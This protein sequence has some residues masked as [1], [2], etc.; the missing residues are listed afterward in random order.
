MKRRDFVAAMRAI[1]R[2][3][4]ATHRV[5]DDTSLAYSLLVMAIEALTRTVEAPLASWLEYDQAKRSRIDKALKEADPE[6]ADRVRIAVLENAHAAVGRLFRDFTI[7]HLAPSFYRAEALD[8]LAP[9][10]RRDLPIVLT[11]AYDLRSGY[12]HRL[13][14]IPK[15]L[16]S[17]FSYVEVMD[18]ARQPTLTIAGLARVVRHVIFR[19]VEKADK[20]EH[21]EFNWR[22]ALPNVMNM[23]WASH[24]WLEH[25]DNYSPESASIWLEHFLGQ[26]SSWLLREPS[27]QTSDLSAVL[28]KIETFHLGS[29]SPAK[30]RSIVALYHLFIMLTEKHEQRPKHKKIIETSAIDFIAPS[31]EELAIRLVLGLHID[32]TLEQQEMLHKTYFEGR[33]AKQAL[34][35]GRLLESLFTLHLAEAN[36]AAGDEQRARELISFSVEAWP[37]HKAL[38]ELEATLGS[39][40][41]NPINAEKIML[42]AA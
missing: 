21:E 15:P 27:T 8:R 11:E 7:T 2:Y 37:G 32:W 22:A 33:S 26:A 41:L 24:Y 10:S 29:I 40:D 4:T 18:I 25:P 12:V 3:V 17:P 5:V 23:Q 42:P 34:R 30:R 36:R 6:V 31:I 19:F 14:A 38:M 20:V 9:V 35:L 13:N 16:L 39:A 28:D 1:Q